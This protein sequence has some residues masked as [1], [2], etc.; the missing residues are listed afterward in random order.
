MTVK[1]TFYDEGKAEVMLN[2]PDAKNAVNFQMIADLEIVLT[3]LEQT[4][5][6]HVVVFRGTGDAFC[7]GGD[8]RQFHQLR[9]ADDAM[10]MLEPMY[11][12]LVRITELAPLTVAHIDGPAVGGGAELAAACDVITG[13][14][15]AKAGFIQGRLVLPP[16]W[17]GSA[18]LKS[19][20][21]MSDALYMLVSAEIFSADELLRFGFIQ[22]LADEP[23][24]LFKAA[25][26]MISYHKKQKQPIPDLAEKMYAD[27]LACAEFW[28]SESH[29]AAVEEALTKKEGPAD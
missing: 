2:R 4:E 24:A 19:K 8:I 11:R 28:A 17:G 18:L 13:T 12:V 29:H 27:V 23:F 14:S 1:L 7:S 5:S 3:E 20:L 10:S 21:Q 22:E 6:L 26:E 16:G 25:P 9:S 15:K